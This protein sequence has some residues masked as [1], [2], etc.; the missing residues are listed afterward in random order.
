MTELGM[1]KIRLGVSACLIGQKVRFDGGHKQNH[2][3]T[4]ILAHYVEFIPV[5]PEVEV[6]LVTPRPALRLV[7]TEPH[8][9]RL[10][11]SKTAQEITPV[12]LDWSRQCVNHLAEQNLDGFIFKANSPSCGMER[13]K[14]YAESG[15]PK[16]IGTGI[17]A[18]AFMERFPLL[19][20]EEEGRL[21]DPQ[22]RENFISSIFTLQRF[23]RTLANHPRY[24]ALVT[25]HT[26]HKLL[27]F[28]HSEKIYREMGRLVAHGKNL[29][30]D[31][32]VERYKNLLLAALRLKTTAS[33]HTNVLQ[34]ILGYFKR[35]LSGDEKQE[36]I[37][38]IEQYKNGLLPLIVP[39]TLVNHF[40][41]KYDQDYLKQQFY[42]RPHPRELKLLNHV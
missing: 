37:E 23:R 13:V 27:I 22:L 4:D 33:K 18:G 2:Y 38:M 32:F 10:V 1:D 29:P 16:K 24:G 34:H 35:Q 5:C 17:F 15:M 6:G 8:A 36:A 21:N 3:L 26:R 11:F 31:E 39:L 12:M 14:L 20:V 28:A 19:P 42:L 41:R 30:L 25:F 7:G 40:V 9:A